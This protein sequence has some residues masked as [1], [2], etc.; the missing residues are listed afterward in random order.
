[1]SGHS[2]PV[3]SPASGAVAIRSALVDGECV[4]DDSAPVRCRPVPKNIMMPDH[5]FAICDRWCRCK[6]RQRVTGWWSHGAMCITYY[7]AYQPATGS[8]MAISTS[9]HADHAR[10]CGLGAPSTTCVGIPV[11]ISRLDP[12][13]LRKLELFCAASKAQSSGA[14]CETFAERK[15]E[16]MKVTQS[17]LHCHF[18]M[19]FPPIILFAG[20]PRTIVS[21]AN[22]CPHCGH[23]RS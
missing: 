4:A 15:T 12:V 20:K 8:T 18:M 22:C 2:C 1:M 21:L 11:T 5:L 10:L 7:L 6:R 13:S 16:N 3:L 23:L 19:T 17:P 14:P 9:T